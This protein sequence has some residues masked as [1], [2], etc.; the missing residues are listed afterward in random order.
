[1]KTIKKLTFLF[2][3][4]L[5]VIACKSDDDGGDGGDAAAGT[6]QAKVNGS[7]FTSLEIATAA[8]QATANGNTTMIIQGSDAE[9]RGIVLIINAFE[10]TETYTLSDDN[11]FI[12]AQYIEVDVNDP[13]N[14]TI[15]AAPFQDSGVVGEIN[16]SEK[17]DTNIKGTFNF[18]AKEQNGTSMRDITEGS[19]NIQ[20]T[21]N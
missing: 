5:A 15:W 9:G 6:I 12:V 18:S 11:V 21:Q 17:T 2:F 13:M 14:P 4:S 16:V 8:N 19:F 3:M 10:G 20:V 1:M 7:N